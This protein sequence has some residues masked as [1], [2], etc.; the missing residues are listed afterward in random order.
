MTKLELLDAIVDFQ[1]DL[2]ALVDPIEGCNDILTL[3]T[4]QETKEETGG[5]L[6]AL[7]RRQQILETAI[8]ALQALL[9]DLY[10]ELPVA[11]TTASVLSDLDDQL[12]TIQAAQVFF[13]LEQAKSLGVTLGTVEP[14]E[15]P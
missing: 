13:R 14:K 3:D 15:T 9:N 2:A 11:E 8:T 1:E 10:P 6:N 4:T 7:T 5:L 12:R